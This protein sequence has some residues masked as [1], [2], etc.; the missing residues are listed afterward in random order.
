MCLLCTEMEGGEGGLGWAGAGGGGGNNYNWKLSN[1]CSLK[2]DG[3][4]FNFFLVT[5]LVNMASIFF[6]FCPSCVYV[7]DDGLFILRL[8]WLKN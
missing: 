8:L 1:C 6:W 7:G 3:A 4:F 5:I 2:K